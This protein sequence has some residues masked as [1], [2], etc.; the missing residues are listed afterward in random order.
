MVCGFLYVTLVLSILFLKDGEKLFS[1]AY[2]NVGTMMVILQ[3]LQM[4]E[5]VHAI[6]GLTKGSI[7][8]T[9]LQIFG[10][11]LVLFA[12][13]VPEPRIQNNIVTF[14][15]FLVWSSVEIVR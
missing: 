1:T 11:S 5:I 2:E 10:R 4:L 7:F 8:T 15:L 6:L 9:V 3:V 14:Y 13:V 12:L